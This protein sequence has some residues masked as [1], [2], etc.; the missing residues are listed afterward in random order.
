LPFDVELGEWILVVGHWTLESAART[1]NR[2][3]LRIY[4]TAFTDGKT[5]EDMTGN[6]S[7]HLKVGDR[8]CW[9]ETLTDLGT[10][11][12][13]SWSG[14]TID[15]DDGHTTSILHNDMAQVELVPKKMM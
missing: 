12:G 1:R 13:T 14:V 8:V 5:Y 11:A 7:R 15:W 6:E 2:S 4:S 9:S 10:V 3:R